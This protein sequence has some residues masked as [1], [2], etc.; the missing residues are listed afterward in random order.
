MVVN[1]SNT[2][3]NY[4]SAVSYS[5]IFH[6]ST[7]FYLSI[8]VSMKNFFKNLREASFKM[9]N[10][11]ILLPIYFIGIGLSKILWYFSKLVVKE[12][13]NGWLKSE[14]LSKK[15]KDYEEMY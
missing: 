13:R 4:Y 12:S 15:L 11:V 10:F 8:G 6:S 7:S 3:N 2:T 14:R 1:P 9:I 5:I